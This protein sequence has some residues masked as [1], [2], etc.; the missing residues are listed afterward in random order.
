VFL[1]AGLQTRSQ[2]TFAAMFIVYLNTVFHL[3]SSSGSL[4]IATK[5][6]AKEILELVSYCFVFYKNK[7]YI[8][9]EHMVPIY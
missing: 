8:F 2:A 9:F 3:H 5:L 6:K 1:I 7:A 4:V